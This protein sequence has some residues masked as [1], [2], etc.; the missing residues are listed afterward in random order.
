L[1]IRFAKAADPAHVFQ[2]LLKCCE[3]AIPTASTAFTVLRA[4]RIVLSRGTISNAD[5]TD[6]YCQHAQQEPYG[7]LPVM[8]TV[9]VLFQALRGA[10]GF[11][12]FAKLPELQRQAQKSLQ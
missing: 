5:D 8:P 3:P 7:R 4:P 12:N 11:V 9:N 1:R 6:A 2:T 10:D